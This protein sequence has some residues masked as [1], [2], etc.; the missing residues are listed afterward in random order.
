M[1]HPVKIRIALYHLFQIR[2]VVFG[3]AVFNFALVWMLDE[4]M[5]GIAA[6]VDPWYHPWSYFNE[7]SRLLLAASFLLI[8]RAWSYLATI[9]LAGYIV[10]RFGYLFA[11]WD[12]TWLQWWTFLRKYEPYFVGSYES[13]V[14]LGLILL[15]LGIFYLVLAP[16]QPKHGEIVGG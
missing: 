8:G 6:L 4:S 10:V 12:G 14:V 5:R 1:R 3:L 13:Q 9:G 7:P 15:C 2:A 16:L 11:I